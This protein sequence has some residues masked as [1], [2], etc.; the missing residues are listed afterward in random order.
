[1]QT[2]EKPQIDSDGAK[3]QLPNLR[4]LFNICEKISKNWTPHTPQGQISPNPPEKISHDWKSRNLSH[5]QET[6]PSPIVHNQPCQDQAH[7]AKKFKFF[8][9]KPLHQSEALSNFAGP[10][11]HLIGQRQDEAKTQ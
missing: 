9:G 8:G 7:P 5:S 2:K 1:M 10:P 3:P 4:K 6:P 11:G